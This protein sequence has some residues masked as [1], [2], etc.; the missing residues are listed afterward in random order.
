MESYLIYKIKNC[1]DHAIQLFLVFHLDNV[2]LAILRD[3][4]N[5]KVCVLPTFA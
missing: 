3:N 4:V 2:V 5:I 1:E